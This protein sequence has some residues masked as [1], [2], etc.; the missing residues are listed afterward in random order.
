MNWRPSQ[1]FAEGGFGRR[2][3]GGGG[4]NKFLYGLCASDNGERRHSISGGMARLAPPHRP[5]LLFDVRN[6]KILN[7]RGNRRV[8]KKFLCVYYSFCIQVRVTGNYEGVYIEDIKLVL[9]VIFLF[10]LLEWTVFYEHQYLYYRK[11]RSLILTSSKINYNLKQKTLGPVS[12]ELPTLLLCE[13]WLAWSRLDVGGLVW[14]LFL[15]ASSLSPAILLDWRQYI[16]RRLADTAPLDLLLTHYSE[17]R[18]TLLLSSD[19]N[20]R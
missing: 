15:L 8:Y 13:F 1:L 9:H 5:F 20:L 11:G 18:I 3:L 14:C 12:G 16:A 7:P 10:I 4:N 6:W 17:L 2:G 19:L